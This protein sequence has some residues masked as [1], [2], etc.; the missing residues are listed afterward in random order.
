M[1]EPIQM[2]VNTNIK[3]YI[4][5]LEE[6]KIKALELQEATEP[7]NDFELEIYSTRIV[8]NEEQEIFKAEKHQCYDQNNEEI[9]DQINQTYKLSKK[10]L[11]E[12]EGKH[13]ISS[14]VDSDISDDGIFSLCIDIE[15]GA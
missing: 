2:E 9:D 3:D 11:K 7:L 4:E 12:I 8:P 1:R 5:L 15:Y 14:S 13:I 10:L 6:V